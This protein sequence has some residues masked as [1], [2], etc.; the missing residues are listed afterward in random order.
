MSEKEYAKG[1]V[2]TVKIDNLGSSNTFI[3]ES[4][5]G[6]TAL[7][8]HPLF[9]KCLVRFSKSELDLVAPNVKDSTERA[10]DFINNNLRYLD[11]N[12]LADHEALSL[13][14][15]VRRRLTGRQK[16]SLANICGAIAEIKLNHQVK[17]AMALISANQAVL[18]EFNL[19]WY[20]NFSE[21]F[22]GKKVIQ[23]KKQRDAIFNIAGFVMAELE[24]PVADQSV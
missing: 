2:V 11:F 8:F 19:M 23:S 4:D 22:S 21:L 7:L 20:R 12:A 15:V 24:N 1:S 16:Q 14:F 3:V 13:Y 6:D 5:C 18:D 9:P 17:E 10:L